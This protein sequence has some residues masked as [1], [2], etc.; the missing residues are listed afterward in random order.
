VRDAIWDTVRGLAKDGRAIM[1]Y[2]ARNEQHLAFKVHR[3]DWQP[4][5]FD[6]VTLMMRPNPP[7]YGTPP[8]EPELRHGWSNQSHY[9]HGRRLRGARHGGK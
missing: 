1:V 6:G 2:S 5:D 3:H 9:R 8:K 7:D 4:T